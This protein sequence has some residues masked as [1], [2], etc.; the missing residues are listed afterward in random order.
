M[1]IL[2][3]ASTSNRYPRPPTPAPRRMRS[4]QSQP[5]FHSPD[6]S[7]RSGYFDDTLPRRASSR[8]PQ[9]PSSGDHYQSYSSEHDNDWYANAG[10]GPG[11]PSRHYGSFRDYGK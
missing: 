9:Q 7:V 11:E 2:T 3:S 10:R 8:H 1:S 6:E 5:D 4:Q